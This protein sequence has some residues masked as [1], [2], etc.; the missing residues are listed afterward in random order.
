MKKLLIVAVLFAQISAGLCILAA[1]PTGTAKCSGCCEGPAG[2][3][4]TMINSCCRIST[5]VLP[6]LEASNPILLAAPLRHAFPQFT[7]I[8][9]P[10][11]IVKYPFSHD[12]RFS[13]PSPPRL[14]LRNS[15]LLI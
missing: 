10:N 7:T 3:H 9:D 2:T 8:A 6:A 5:P 4:G 15:A 1:S 12:L 11:C 14:F 13:D